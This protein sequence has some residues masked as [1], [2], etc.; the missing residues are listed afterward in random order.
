MSENG[1]RFEHTSKHFRASCELQHWKSGIMWFLLKWELNENGGMI[2]VASL[3]DNR[4]FGQL[5]N[6][7][8][9]FSQ[10]VLILEDLDKCFERT[11][12]KESSIY[13]AMVYV[14]YKMHI[15]MIPSASE[16]ET[17]KIVWS[18]A[19]QEQLKGSFLPKIPQISN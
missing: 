1:A 12:I 4:L 17:A 10:P 15:A 8:E 9:I 6:M 14:A 19:K 7:T 2:F 5:R 18:F 11:G 3:L 16:E 13:G